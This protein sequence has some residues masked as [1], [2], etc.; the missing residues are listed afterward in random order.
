VRRFFVDENLAPH[1][2]AAL[3]AVYKRDKFRSA[4]IEGLRGVSDL[5]LF[6]QL[7]DRAFDC[8]ITLDRAQTE[9]EVERAGIRDAGLHWLG[10]QQPSGEGETIHSRLTAMA[11]AGL[12]SLLGDWPATPHM[13]LVEASMVAGRIRIEAL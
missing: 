6:G 13:F 7:R 4:E 9:N 8:I 12:P 1:V 11:L 3:N 5:D 2:A 10:L